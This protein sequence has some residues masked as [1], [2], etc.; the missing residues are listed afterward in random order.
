LWAIANQAGGVP[1][2]QSAPYLYQLKGSAISEVTSLF[3]VAG[4]I[5]DPPNASLFESANALA[6]PLDGTTS[7]VSAL[8]QSAS[9]TRWDVFTFGTDSSL[10]TGPGWDNVTDV[11]TPNAVPF[12][13]QV[14][15]LSK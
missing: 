14:V 5:F 1:L 4:V 12:I 3:N 11:G 13:Q 9:S 2:D 8:F 6:A 7:Y 10:Q 15:A